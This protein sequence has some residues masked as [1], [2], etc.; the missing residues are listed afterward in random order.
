M[1]TTDA[2]VQVPSPRTPRP[3]ESAPKPLLRPHPREEYW[4][5]EQCAWVPGTDSR[6]EA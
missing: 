4:D 2:D 6:R 5:L 1:P 3:V